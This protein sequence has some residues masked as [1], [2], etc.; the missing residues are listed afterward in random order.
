LDPINIV[1]LTNKAAVYFEQKDWDNCIKECE[2]A[3]EIGRENK[4]DYKVI[5]KAYA[6]IANVYAQQKDY[7]QAVKYYNHS[8][9]EHR[10][11]EVLKKNKKLKK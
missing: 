3:I 1:Y 11:P 5:A 7:Q 8:L 9:S 10:N 2:K 4:V 6:R